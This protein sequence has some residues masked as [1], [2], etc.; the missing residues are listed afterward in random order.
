MDL[1]RGL[2][3]NV[4]VDSFWGVC[5]GMYS[6]GF[7]PKFSGLDLIFVCFCHHLSFDLLRVGSSPCSLSYVD[8]MICTSD[9]CILS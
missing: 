9:S 6:R 1:W 2:L 8:V 7:C 5:A 3:L 4:R